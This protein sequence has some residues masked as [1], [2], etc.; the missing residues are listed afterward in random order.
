MQ[1]NCNKEMKY[2]LIII[3]FYFPQLHALPDC[4]SD[5]MEW[6]WDNCFGT[7]KY[8]N[9]D[10]Y[11]G[12]WKDGLHHGQGTYISKFKGDYVGEFKDGQYHGQG[13]FN[14][15]DGSQFTGEWKNNSK[16]QGILTSPDG[17][18]YVGEFEDGK[19]HGRGTYTFPS[20]K[21]NRGY[22][23]AGMY[24]PN[25]CKNMATVKYSNG[26]V[27]IKKLRGDYKKIQDPK[28]FNQ[29]VDELNSLAIDPDF[30]VLNVDWLK[31]YDKMQGLYDDHQVIIKSPPGTPRIKE[32]WPPKTQVI[33]KSPPRL[34]PKTKDE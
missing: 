32:D 34:P 10:E 17:Y 27:V 11:Y 16:Q 4:P 14:Y 19:R 26:A 8:E 12:E 20:G 6:L 28:T 25:I 13:T 21:R 30:Y 31:L 9:G 3:L 5:S 24:V 33:I 18:K 23:V 7:F 2:L 15:G 29:C 1:D 22:F